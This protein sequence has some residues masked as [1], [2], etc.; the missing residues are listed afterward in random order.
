[1]LSGMALRLPLDLWLEPL[2]ISKRVMAG[3]SIVWCVFAHAGVAYRLPR[4]VQHTL[5]IV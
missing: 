5:L 3:S 2:R 1:M 4:S